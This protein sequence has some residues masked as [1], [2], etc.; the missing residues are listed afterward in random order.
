VTHEAEMLAEEVYPVSPDRTL[1]FVFEMG[2]PV[3]GFDERGAGAGFGPGELN[4]VR[5]AEIPN[6][7]C[8]PSPLHA[9]ETKVPCEGI[10]V[11]PNRD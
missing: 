7:L 4:A 3:C 2:H 10:G 5:S 8:C 11:Y 9:T 1:P 6:A